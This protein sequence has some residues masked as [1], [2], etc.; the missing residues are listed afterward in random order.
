MQEKDYLLALTQSEILGPS[1]LQRLRGFFNTWEKIWKASKHD[2][3]ASGLAD[4][5]LEIF[6]QHRE[7][8]DLKQAYNVLSNHNINFITID[9]PGY[10]SQLK[11]ISLPPPLLYYQGNVTIFTNPSIAVVGRRKLTAYG[12]LIIKNLLPSLIQNNFLIISGLALGV[13]GLAHQLTLDQSGKTAAVLGSSLDIIYPR[14]HTKL[15]KH[16]A[17]HGCLVSEFKPDTPPLKYN[18]PQRNRLIAGLAQTTLVIEAGAKSGALSTAAYAKKQQRPILTVPGNIF[19]HNLDGNHLLLKNGAHLITTSSDILKLYNL[20][21]PIKMPSTNKINLTSEE[22]LILQS[23]STEPQ[24]IDVI[25]KKTKLD[26]SVINSRLTIM[27]IKGQ[28]KHTGNMEY[29]SLTP[30]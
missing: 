2:L 30:Q 10:P 12:E 3:Q 7:H 9:E 5:I 28:V 22:L 19:A 27:E 14:L 24:H 26:M 15:A 8:F 20:S 23:L 11:K 29:I 4:H 16:I 21:E 25:Q 6:L 17:T 13:D 1:R 18:F